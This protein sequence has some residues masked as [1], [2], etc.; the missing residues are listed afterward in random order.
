MAKFELLA[1]VASSLGLFAFLS[2]VLKV[3]RTYN[4]KAITNVSLLSNLLAQLLL[5]IY[6]YTNDLK[7][8]MYPIIIYACG[9]TYVVYVKNVINKERVLI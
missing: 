3:G 1:G 6:A 4:T 8:L 5:F 2:I 9:L 7:G